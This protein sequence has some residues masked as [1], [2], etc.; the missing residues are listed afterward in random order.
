MN[1]LEVQISNALRIRVHHLDVIAQVVSKM[2]SIKTQIGILRICF[3]QISLN[4]LVGSDMAICMGV[5][6]L[7]DTKFIKERL[8]KFVMSCSKSLPLF[9]GKSARFASL[10]R[11]IITP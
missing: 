8:A 11:F 3:L 10:A 1:L 6:L 7:M 9:V 5:E 4:F 2:A